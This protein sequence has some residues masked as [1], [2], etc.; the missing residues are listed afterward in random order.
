[1]VQVESG[2][3]IQDSGSGF[4][5]NMYGCTTLLSWKDDITRCPYSV[6]VRTT[7]GPAD[8]AVEFFVRLAK[9][10]HHFHH[11]YF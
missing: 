10:D 2:S 5:R 11:M 4:E 7:G 1:M 6:Q 9:G 8:A 3:V